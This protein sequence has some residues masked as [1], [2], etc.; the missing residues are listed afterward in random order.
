MLDF[1]QRVI[2]ELD[3]VAERTPKLRAFLGTDLFCSLPVAEQVRL[4]L[5]LYF[6][7]G[8]QEVLEERIAAFSQPAD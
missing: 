4:K 2:E 3:Q 6:M 7:Q 1:Q 5:Q 8:Y